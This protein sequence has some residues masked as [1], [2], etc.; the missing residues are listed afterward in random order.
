MKTRSSK[1][2]FYLIL[3]AAVLAFAVLIT[4]IVVINISV[5]VSTG[6]KPDLVICIASDEHG[7]APKA[8]ET[9]ELITP[10]TVNLYGQQDYVFNTSELWK[11]NSKVNIFE[12]NDPH[13]K[14]DGTGEANNV[15][16]P[17][18]S[19]EFVFSLQNDTSDNLVYR[20]E[21]T[22]DNDTKYKIPV[23]V[24]LHDL[25]GNY[26]DTPLTDIDGFQLIQGAVV[27][28]N[29]QRSYELYWE[30][31]FDGDDEYDTML[32]NTA[33]NE[34]I[35]CHININVVAEPVD[36]SYMTFLVPFIEPFSEP[37]PSPPDDSV[38]TGDNTNAVTFAALT[39]LLAAVVI[40]VAFK[41]RRKGSL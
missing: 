8:Q 15:I 6:V 25:T 3:T 2:P 34:E 21:V 40:T 39:C 12:H 24:R 37:A 13:V 30:W 10:P 33:V 17:G 16:A 23:K 26:P 18:T 36:V 4:T 22:G 32:G 1:K 28:A 31:A 7:L 38:K 20:L 11:T 5:P 35:S 29:S 14:S 9:E 27:G 19:N 41:K